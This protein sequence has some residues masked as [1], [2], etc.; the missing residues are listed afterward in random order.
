MQFDFFVHLYSSP[1]PFP[2]T[3]TAIRPGST[4]L[5]PYCCCRRV[6]A[7]RV[8][9]PTTLTNDDERRRLS[10]CR[11]V[12]GVLFVDWM[13]LDWHDECPT[14]QKGEQKVRRKG[15]NSCVYCVGVAVARGAGSR[16]GSCGTC[17]SLPLCTGGWRLG[18]NKQKSMIERQERGRG[19][20]RG[21]REN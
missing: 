19:S 11:N 4:W 17:L 1:P 7:P 21:G 12:C 15:R 5:P 2:T 13:C 6:S 8:V 18:A 9:S 16:S 14:G 10:F 20:T 3:T